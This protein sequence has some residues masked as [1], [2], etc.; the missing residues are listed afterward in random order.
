MS[1][2]SIG[3]YQVVRPLGAG[4]MGEVLLAI[5]PR[6]ER[7]VA[8]KVLRSDFAMDPMAR[9]RFHREAKAL[10][11]LRHP[12]VVT[13]HEIGEDEGLDFIVMEFLEG[14]NLRVQ[15]AGAQFDDAQI[16]DLVRQIADAM[17]GAHGAGVLHRDIK[18]ENIMV[19]DDNS[20][21]VVDFGLARSFDEVEAGRPPSPD[22]VVDLMGDTL[23]VT[24]ALELG[25]AKTAPGETPTPQAPKAVPIQR[26][27]A[28][29]ETILGTPAYMAPELFLGRAPTTAS[30]VYSLG[31]LL[32]EMFSGGLPYPADRLDDLL[33]ERV[34][35]DK[36]ATRLDVGGFANAEVATLV[37]SLL[38]KD[39][40]AR[41]TITEFS[42]Q[43]ETAMGMTTDRV[44]P[45]PPELRPT[46]VALSQEI[47]LVSARRRRQR[48]GVGRWGLGV[49]MLGLL[50]GGALYA[51]STTRE[52]HR[53]AE[54]AASAVGELEENSIRVAIKPLA[55][56]VH[57]YA[58]A[59]RAV[60]TS[61]ATV[62]SSLLDRARAIQSIPPSQLLNHIGSGEHDPSEWLRAGHDVG[63]MYLVDASLEDD[64]QEFRGTIKITNLLDRSVTSLPVMA[65]P[66]DKLDDLLFAMASAIAENTVPGSR[67]V[68]PENDAQRSV[69][70][71]ALYGS[72]LQDLYDNKW[73]QACVQLERIVSEQ[74]NFFEAWY[75]LA[76][77]SAWAAQ[78]RE[79]SL[80]AAREALELASTSR[81]RELMQAVIL[82]I[83]RDFITASAEG[84]GLARR[85]PRDPEIAY[86]HAETVYHDGRYGEALLL[87][88]EAIRLAPRSH[89]PSTHPI[90]HAEATGNR[91]RWEHYHALRAAHT[92][93]ASE[94]PRANDRLQYA[95]GEYELLLAEQG[96]ESLWGLRVLSTLQRDQEIDRRLAALESL[97][98][99]LL[100]HAMARAMESGDRARASALFRQGYDVIKAAADQPGSRLNLPSFP[101]V[102]IVGGMNEELREFLGYWS[103]GGTEKNGAQEANYRAFSAV[104][105]ADRSLVRRSGYGSWR[106]QERAR[107]ILA[108]LD[109]RSEEAATI[110]RSLLSDPSQWGDLL[111]RVAL[112]R[113]LHKL[114]KT[115]ELRRECVRLLRPKQWRPAYSVARMK[116]LEWDAMP[117][118]QDPAG[119]FAKLDP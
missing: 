68:A 11:S 56:N 48:R 88:D 87:F 25:R 77:A 80:H 61:A 104:G 115:E 1:A 20:I 94:H 5:D 34:Y 22:A 30:D 118:K 49:M 90:Q 106:E 73:V 6:L 16:I 64:K 70:S 74:P 119:S 69:D 3:G 114:G 41:P 95:L 110:L 75:H 86:L 42:G 65:R 55:S 17:A 19:L 43:L 51:A 63:A 101:E 37:E 27:T 47:D 15:M 66:L 31:V 12:G 91:E 72:A 14:S 35:S 93:D 62:L 99:E 109:G 105:L 50:V 59:N 83:G 54:R 53:S 112:A 28:N 4:G 40:E 23:G 21:R 76:I 52:Q 39:P 111:D 8:I 97:T 98:G 33:R 32:Y 24:G 58:H 92:P 36:E 108:E 82:Y 2:R 81:D 9:K 102:L 46:E 13:I 96:E 113:N 38:A 84:A 117:R 57:G 78:P 29:T 116:C 71:L 100:A 7:H 107:A 45:L 26:L 67:L 79:K 44:Q 10:A 85:F 18:P 89:L 60:G 103:L